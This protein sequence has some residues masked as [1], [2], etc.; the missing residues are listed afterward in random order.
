MTRRRRTPQQQAQVQINQQQLAQVAAEQP[1]RKCSNC[2][3]EMFVQVTK[4]KFISKFAFA[5]PGPLVNEESYKVCSMCNQIYNL[6]ADIDEF[7]RGSK[8]KEVKPS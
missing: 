2:G 6:D 8:Q 3:G 5:T 1:Y 7:E 4:I